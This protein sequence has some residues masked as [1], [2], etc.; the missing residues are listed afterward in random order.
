MTARNQGESPG[1][2]LSGTP[3]WNAPIQPPT[4]VSVSEPALNTRPVQ[5]RSTPLQFRV[6][7]P[8][9]KFRNALH[10]RMPFNTYGSL[11][12][13]ERPESDSSGQLGDKSA[14]AAQLWRADQSKID[15]VVYSYHTPIAWHVT[16][17]NYSE[18]IYPDVRYSATTSAQQNKIRKALEANENQYM[19]DSVRDIREA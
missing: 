14:A 13:R 17:T 7:D 6:R 10:D 5:R 3:W 15:Y 19:I 8:W 16:G 9:W 12:G 11:R 4:S 2:L 18:W 1:A